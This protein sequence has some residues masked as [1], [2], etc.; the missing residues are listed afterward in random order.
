MRNAKVLSGTYAM[1]RKVVGVDAAIGSNHDLE[2]V[3]STHG[4]KVTS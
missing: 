2:V 1:T 3:G 4:T